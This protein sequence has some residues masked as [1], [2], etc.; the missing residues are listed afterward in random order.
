MDS[1]VSSTISAFIIP[2]DPES[3]R[4]QLGGWIESATSVT[5]YQIPVAQCW[6]GVQKEAVPDWC[7]S[8]SMLPIWRQLPSD[9]TRRRRNSVQRLPPHDQ[10]AASS[11]SSSLIWTCRTRAT[12]SSAVS[13]RSQVI[14]LP[15][16]ACC[17]DELCTPW[18]LLLSYFNLHYGLQYLKVRLICWE[19]GKTIK[20]RP[21][22]RKHELLLYL[23][24]NYCLLVSTPS[25]PNY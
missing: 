13:Q 25:V 21:G 1:L 4:P 10:Q 6:S 16:L 2:M 24:C 23:V 3:H 22:A 7:M 19:G 5:D 9:S 18:A 11:C 12:N 17:Y 8:F 14:L 15:N 20:V